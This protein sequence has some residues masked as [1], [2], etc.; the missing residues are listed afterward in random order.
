MFKFIGVAIS[1]IKSF[2]SEDGKASKSKLSLF[3]IA[4]LAV[5]FLILTNVN[6]CGKKKVAEC[7]E[8]ADCTILESQF[9]EVKKDLEEKLAVQ[10]QINESSP[11]GVVVQTPDKEF[12]EKK[13]YVT[14]LER[15]EHYK[16]LYLD[17]YK[18]LGA[19]VAELEKI[20]DEDFEQGDVII[21]GLEQ[22][23]PI[24]K[25]I[26]QD[27]SKNHK[28]LVEIESEGALKNYKQDLKIFPTIIEVP[29]KSEP[30]KVKD[31][32]KNFIAAKVGIVRPSNEYLPV[33]S[34]QYG[35]WILTVEGGVLYN[36]G[37]DGIKGLTGQV[38]VV[39]KFK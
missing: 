11:K 12:V 3:G 9:A 4:L 24:V 38:G 27:S 1:G 18:K 5:L 31:N 6:G 16:S 14:T 23:K 21:T 30:I 29:T 10:I 32:R 19:T 22:M 28:L 37:F 20:K 17:A 7:P 2:F 26:K 36:P 35:W 13:I 25:T 8:C 33:T 39:V 34:L 15:K